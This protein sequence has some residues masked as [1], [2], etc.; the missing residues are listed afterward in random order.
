MFVTLGG[1]SFRP[2]II[3]RHH[4][5]VFAALSELRVQ[6]LHDCPCCLEILEMQVIALLLVVSGVQNVHRPQDTMLVQLED[7]LFVKSPLALP[8]SGKR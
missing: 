2:A 5:F 8:F 4:A 1:S 7:M 6:M 3:D